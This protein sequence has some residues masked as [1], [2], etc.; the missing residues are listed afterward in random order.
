M[1]SYT[2]ASPLAMAAS[3]GAG[4]LSITLLIEPYLHGEFTVGAAVAVAVSV[5]VVGLT[6]AVGVLAHT[7]GRSL[8]GF[9]LALLSLCG[10]G[11]IVWEQSGR[12]AQ[13]QVATAVTVGDVTL[14]RRRL[15]QKRAEADEILVKHRADQARECASGKG[16]RCDGISYTVATWEAAVAGYD[17]RLRG[18][19]APAPD[20]KSERAATVAGLLGRDPA[21]ARTWVSLLDPLAMPVWLEWVSVLCGILA[22]RSS[23]STVSVVSPVSEVPKPVETAR[24]LLPKPPHLCPVQ[25]EPDEAR[26]L[27]ALKA[28][29]G[30]V[31][32]QNELGIAIGVSKG[33]VSKMLRHCPNVERIRVDNRYVIRIKD[34]V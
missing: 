31:D 26:V 25:V 4:V 6:I 32:S 12:R 7:M 23:G 3:V 33:E 11:L 16:K 2:I 10:S 29:G 13:T 8:A 5:G 1:S 14:E 28:K 17:A 30:K 20:A 15:I 9:G 18:I 22:V 27:R 19:P 34:T 24:K 21:A